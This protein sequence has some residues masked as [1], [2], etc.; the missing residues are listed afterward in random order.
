[1][2]A[3]LLASTS[4]WARFEPEPPTPTTPPAPTDSGES[5][6]SVQPP[7]A[8][9]EAPEPSPT[10]SEPELNE[11]PEI[12][13]GS[14]VELIMR[15]GRRLT[16]IYVDRNAEQIN[17]SIAGIT[18][19]FGV[20][21]VERMRPVP[22]VEERYEAWRKSI[23]PDD[24]VERI[25]LSRWLLSMKRLSLALEEI[26]RALMIDPD[27]QPAKDLR[28]T[29]LAQARLEEEKKSAPAPAPTPRVLKP[30]FPL[31]TDAQ[32]NLMRIFEVDLKDPPRMITK[33]ETTRKF[34]EAYSGRQA[35]ELGTI[36]TTPE[37]RDVFVRK[38]VSEILEW[39]FELRAREFY[40]EIEVTEDPRAMR[41]FRDS[42][43]RNWL[44]NSCATNRCHGGEDAGR[45]QLFNRNPNS[46][47][48]VYTNFLIL[49]RFRLDDGRP[50]ISY[51]SPADS[52][53][54]DYGLPLKD[55]VRKHPEVK[56]LGRGKWQP[57]FSGR[58]DQRYIAAIEWIRAMYR[59]RAEY[60]VEYP[61]GAGRP[62]Q[63]SPGPRAVPVPLDATPPTPADPAKTDPQVPATLPT[64]E[65]ADGSDVPNPA[66][67]PKSSPQPR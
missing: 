7:A 58:D 12:Q 6:E 40:G 48:S 3:M 59:P 41:L 34:L 31:L 33:P 42:V 57:V 49:D 37:G 53:L 61:P 45:L 22:T 60:P 39:M 28:T 24:V 35:R 27:S 23:D 55:A 14:E 21:F 64:S 18:T 29:I 54:L 30:Q 47:H 25:R 67:D 36:P 10:K 2:A 66:S 63:P 13:P 8:S 38:P 43:H 51:D 9:P 62:V 20:G 5:P 46:K 65:P 32:I 11:P 16:G 44:I 1:M 19:P 15:D 26:D 17:I 50:L 4:T 52:V 56:G